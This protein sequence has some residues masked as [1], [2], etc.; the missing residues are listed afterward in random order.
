MRVLIYGINYA[1]EVTS[2]GKYTTEMA[3]ALAQE[4]HEVRVVTSPPYY[5]EWKVHENYSAWRYSKDKYNGVLVLRCPLWVPRHPYGARRLLH[6][7]SFAI[8]SIPVMIRQAFWR[9]ALVW[10]VEPPIVCAPAALIVA[11]LCGGKSWLHIQDFE[12][13]AAFN[14]K[15][16]K[17]AWLR[18]LVT[19][20]ERFLMKRFDRVSSIS[21]KMVEHALK[22]GIRKERSVLFPNWVN[23]K[24]IHPLTEP[25]AYRTELRLP[26][27]CIVALYSGNM[28]AKQGL[29][30]LAAVARRHASDPNLFF[31]FCGNGAMRDTLVGQCDGLSNVHFMDVQPY[32]RLN[33]LLGMADI[34][35]LPQRADAADLVM[36]SKLTGM[37]ASGK[38]IVAA[39]D[40]DTELANLLDGCAMVVK[41]GCVQS[42]ADAIRKL[43]G[44]PDL[45]REFGSLGR[46]LAERD[47]AA[48]VVLGGFFKEMERCVAGGDEANHRGQTNQ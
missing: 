19:G 15:L 38:S 41:P 3:E 42:F 6:L 13:D 28:G 5:P 39:A 31:V 1:P 14:L 11:K 27:N 23:V 24:L 16:I 32:E 26:S 18:V 10:L 48:S 33:E 47:F 34:H 37:L 45:R 44:N 25:S 8:S 36:P 9:P 35:L 4:G 12:I 43:S 20:F 2:T 7:I 22:K 40:K 46:K 30:V 21:G 29:E 17:A